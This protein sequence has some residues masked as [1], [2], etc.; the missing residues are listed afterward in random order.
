VNVLK[1]D[2]GE[3]DESLF[4]DVERPFE[5]IFYILGIEKSDLNEVA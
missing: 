3:V 4:H 2:F 1:F 5:R